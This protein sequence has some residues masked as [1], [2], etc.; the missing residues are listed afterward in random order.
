MDVFVNGR[1]EV[2]KIKWKTSKKGKGN[3]WG[4]VFTNA[5]S[6]FLRILCCCFSSMLGTGSSVCQRLT[7]HRERGKQTGREEGKRGR[8]DEGRQSR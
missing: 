4:V 7:L 3:V 5:F 2:T 8:R 6:F 1:W